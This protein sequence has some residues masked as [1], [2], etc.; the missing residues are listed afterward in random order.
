[1]SISI[2]R[3]YHALIYV[4]TWPQR[5]TILIELNDKCHSFSTNINNKLLLKTPAYSDTARIP[6]PRLVLFRR[7]NTLY[8]LRKY[9]VT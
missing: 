9:S 3:V 1:M 5:D 2:I 7:V 4:N 8:P 6:P